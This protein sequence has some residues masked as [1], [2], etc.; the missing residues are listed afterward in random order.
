ASG[1]E[2]VYLASDKLISLLAAAASTAVCANLLE[3][4]SFGSV[5]FKLHKGWARDLAI[6]SAVGALALTGSIA[7][8]RFAG[9]VSFQR[10]EHELPLATSLVY[11]LAFMLIAAATEELIFRGFVFQA[12]AHDLGPYTAVTATALL[13]GLAHIG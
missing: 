12:L 8:L 1:G 2:L 11:S 4:R 7:I 13:F 3:R 5:G 10:Y 6:G 9:A